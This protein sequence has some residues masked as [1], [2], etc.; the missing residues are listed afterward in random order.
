M[1]KGVNEQSVVC[2][3]ITD[4]ELCKAWDCSPV[5]T[6]RL[7]TSGELDYC[8]VAGSIRYTPEAIDSYLNRNKARS[9]S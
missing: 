1:L 6:W 9:R 3:L 5:T 8:R 7:R 2:R 4:K